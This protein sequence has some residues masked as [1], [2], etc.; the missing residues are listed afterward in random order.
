MDHPNHYYEKILSPYLTTAHPNLF[1]SKD[2]ISSDTTTLKA[3]ELHTDS[4][5]GIV[6]IPGITVPRESCYRLFAH[7]QNHNVLTYDL[8]GQA[9]SGGVLNWEKCMADINAIG[10]DFKNRRKLQ[11]LIGIGHSFGGLIRV[12]RS[13]Y[14]A[15]H[16]HGAEHYG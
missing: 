14:G 15:G 16:R 2:I 8:R 7:F 9:D 10:R 1:I 5:T 6:I 13:L 3:T 12:R 4:S 11:H